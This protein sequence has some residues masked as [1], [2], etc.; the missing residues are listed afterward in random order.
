MTKASLALAVALAL[1]A[2][3]ATAADKSA[4]NAE[5]AATY[6]R[7]YYRIY[8]Q[9][10]PVTFYVAS[11]KGGDEC[12]RAGR[13]YEARMGGALRDETICREFKRR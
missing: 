1:L 10:G 8:T 3:T 5:K 11:Y 2:G 7:L 12:Q 4:G 6:W 13:D 9:R